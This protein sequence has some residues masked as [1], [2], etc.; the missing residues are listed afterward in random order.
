[1]NS[2][3]VFDVDNDEHPVYRYGSYVYGG[4]AVLNYNNT[5]YLHLSILVMAIVYPKKILK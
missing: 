1:M 4:E 3:D 5:K 2:R